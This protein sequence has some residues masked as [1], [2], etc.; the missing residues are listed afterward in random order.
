[1]GIRY[2][3]YWMKSEMCEWILYI[4][5]YVDIFCKFLLYDTLN[6][7]IIPLSEGYIT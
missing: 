5:E 1:M 3:D 4:I 6:C 2:D 7:H